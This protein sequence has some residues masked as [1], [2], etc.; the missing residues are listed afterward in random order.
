MDAAK[1]DFV[2]D[3]DDRNSGH[4]L[5]VEMCGA[6][7]RVLEAGCA[8]GYVSKVLTE[9]GCKV[10]GLD[11]D[12]DA[13][14]RAARYCERTLVADL[15]TF[16]L[17]Q[18]FEPHSF[19]VAMF[20][21]VLEHLR[22][23]VGV[24]RRVRPLLTPDGYVVASIPNVAHGAVRLSLLTGRFDYRP[25]GLLD[26]THVR[27]FTRESIGDMFQEAGFVVVETR[28]TVVGIFETEIPLDPE[29]FDPDVVERIADEEESTTYQFVVKAV[30]DNGLD[31]VRR[32][33]EREQRQH[34]Q[35]ER[36]EQQLAE[37]E[38]ERDQLYRDHAALWQRVNTSEASLDEKHRELEATWARIHAYEAYLASIERRLPVRVYR[39]LKAIGR[40]LGLVRAPAGDPGDP[41]RS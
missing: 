36:L 38:T 28:R 33:H 21:D 10:T 20:G 6:N 12:E 9:R 5:L 2:V 17:S 3:L 30:I 14:Q 7:K 32:L 13:V 1:Y 41:S 37:A 15:E 4:T 25:T 39:K 24:L 27:F 26:D 18:E 23:P 35:I 19:D 11:V 16:D 31:A 34:M 29:A 22:D 8:T 40:R